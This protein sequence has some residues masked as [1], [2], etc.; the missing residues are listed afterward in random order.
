MERLSRAE[1]DLSIAERRHF[2][3]RR[4][5]Q[6]RGE[7]VQLLAWRQR[8]LVGWVTLLLRSKYGD[9]RDRLG[10]FPEMNALAARPQGQGIG[11]A[12]IRSAEQAAREMG[13]V[14]IGL[15]VG[16]DNDG[17]V[18]LYDR[19]GYA[20]WGHGPVVDRWTAYDDAGAV[21]HQ[22]A[23]LCAYLIKPLSPAGSNGP[24]SPTGSA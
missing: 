20:D 9:V 7:S 14:R 2:E 11:T 18:R 3:E 8:Q 21:V 24:N 23:S 13:A 6:E 4:A 12:L 17:A 5:V 19:L 1:L 22:H 15:A 16:A 10:D